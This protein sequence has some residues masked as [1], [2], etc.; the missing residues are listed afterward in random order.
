[1]APYEK[2]FIKYNVDR[3]NSVKKEAEILILAQNTY[4][5]S[6][7]PCEGITIYCAHH[8][9]NQNKQKCSMEY[10]LSRP[11]NQL[12]FLNSPLFGIDCYWLDVNKLYP[13]PECIGSCNA[14]MDQSS[15]FST[16]YVWITAAVV[17]F[18]FILAAILC[19]IYHKK[20]IAKIENENS[21]DI[22]NPL[23]IIVPIGKYLP[24]KN[25][26]KIKP[27]KEILENAVFEDL[28]SVDV[29]VANLVNV[30]RDKLKYDVR[31]KELKSKKIQTKW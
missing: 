4:E 5:T 17:I 19:C 15:F 18:I 8:N 12:Q 21:I 16:V 22:R 24:N 6:Q 10:K 11:I 25:D 30:F 2:H 7:L 9:A 3:S 13:H 26:G 23:V 31:I 27:D 28:D 1:M 20:K 29:D 14:E